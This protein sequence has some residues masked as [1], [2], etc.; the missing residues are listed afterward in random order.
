M[1]EKKRYSLWRCGK[2]DDKFITDCRSR[3]DMVFCKCGESG[4]DDEEWY[5]RGVGNPVLV[6]SSDDENELLRL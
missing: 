2:C 4:I 6:D 5:M 3:W 1:K